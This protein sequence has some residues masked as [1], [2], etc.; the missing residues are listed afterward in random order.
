[1]VLI[2]AGTRFSITV[3][4]A[5]YHP[6]SCPRQH[7]QEQPAAQTRPGSQDNQ[8]RVRTTA[9]FSA[10]AAASGSHRMN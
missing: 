7:R 10:S 5:M 6:P 1:M 4:T 9:R 3:R 2:R 8:D